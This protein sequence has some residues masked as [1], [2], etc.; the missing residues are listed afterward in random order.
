MLCNRTATGVGGSRCDYARPIS[1]RS[2]S[3]AKPWKPSAA[4]GS[5]DVSPRSGSGNSHQVT[6]RSVLIHAVDP[7]G[8]SAALPVLSRLQIFHLSAVSD[9][10][11][12]PT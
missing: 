11:K 3:A 8:A 10:Q 9:R 1:I 7:V 6:E 12:G 2:S 4:I 5:A